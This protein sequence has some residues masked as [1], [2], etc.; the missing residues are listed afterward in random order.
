M[1][2]ECQKTQ[3]IKY[4]SQKH[5]LKLKK[6]DT[7]STQYLLAMS[8]SLHL[9]HQII[10]QFIAFLSL[11]NIIISLKNNTEKQTNKA[12][13]LALTNWRHAHVLTMTLLC[14]HIA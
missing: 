12:S 14:V 9:P 5:K 13:N 8:I 1:I 7:E 2:Q 11:K 4:I 3:S 10:F 6:K